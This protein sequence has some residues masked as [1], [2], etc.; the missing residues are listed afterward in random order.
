MSMSSLQEDVCGICNVRSYKRDLR[1]APLSKIP[2]IELLKVPID[3]YDIIPRMQE[4]D[5]FQSHDKLNTS[6]DLVMALIQKE[7]AGGWAC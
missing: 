7:K 5:Q 2:S 3:F 6:D 1:Y 4:T